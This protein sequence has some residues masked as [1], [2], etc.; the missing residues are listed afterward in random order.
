MK[1][2]AKG[3][4]RRMK[5]SHGRLWAEEFVKLHRR[6]CD[7]NEIRTVDADSVNNR[8]RFYGI[9]VVQLLYEQKLEQLRIRANCIRMD[10]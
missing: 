6:L 3:N 2:M 4:K 10:P 5:T 9:H 1:Q 7:Y 8:V